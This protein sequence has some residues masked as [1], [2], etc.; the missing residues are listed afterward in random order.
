MVL[1]R[2][3]ACHLLCQSFRRMIGIIKKK[4]IAI[5]TGQDNLIIDIVDLV[6]AGTATRNIFINKAGQ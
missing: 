5:G 2:D 4:K 1:D 3:D 6:P